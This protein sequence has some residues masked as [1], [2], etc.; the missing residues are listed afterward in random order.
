[1]TILNTTIKSLLA[2][3]LFIIISC[4][5]PQIYN[6]T[7]SVTLPKSYTGYGDT[8]N[9]GF[10]NWRKFFN[11]NTLIALIDLALSNNQE[12]NIL[13]QELNIASNDVLVRKAA[14]IP[15][16]NL[17]MGTGV[18]KV[19]EYTPQGASN[20][21]TFILP[22][23]KMPEPSSDYL[24]NLK[25]SWEIDIWGKLKNYKKAALH[26]YLASV[27]GKNFAIT[28]LVAEVANT[29]YELLALNNQIE[30]LK[31]NIN[32]QTNALEIVKFEKLAA[33]VTELAVKKFEA[34][35][36][37]NQSKQYYIEQQIII[38]EN[39][40]NFLIGRFPQ[41]IKLDNINLLTTPLDTVYAGVPSQMLQNRT[42]IRQAQQ[43]LNAAKINAKAVK[44]EFYPNIT[45]TADVGLNAFKP[46]YLL[47]LPGSIIYNFAGDLMMPLL[48]RNAIKAEY[49]N[50]NAKQ[51]QSIFVYEQSLIKAH[52]EVINLLNGLSNLTKSYS[53][54]NKEVDALTESTEISSTLF[55]SARADYMEVLLTQRDALDAK[56]DLVD[57]KLQQIQTRI[58]LYKA[59]GGGWK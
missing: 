15:K 54:K 7:E 46:K 2:S 12:L 43:N 33:K 56:I 11:D 47:E 32:V 51:L 36:F 5:V 55:K 57:I 30:L 17:G 21:T 6:K 13:T 24:L 37:K 31:K 59:L 10:I 1:M 4:K 26:K 41:P 19:G 16:V 27:E 35:V 29:Y 22:N 40:I 49:F 39:K 18:D 28:T 8:T 44:A 3:F 42:D 38:T 25:F 53:L 52:I 23:E 45:L 58:N 48:N 20:K 50:A 9:S 34:E 14:Y